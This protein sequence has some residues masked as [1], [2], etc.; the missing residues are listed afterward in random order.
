MLE[1]IDMINSSEVDNNFIGDFINCLFR[2]NDEIQGVVDKLYSLNP[3]E[4][5]FD[6]DINMISLILCES[7]NYKYSEI[8]EKSSS[9]KEELH[10]ASATAQKFG[11]NGLYKF[12]EK[13][14][15]AMVVKKV[16]LLLENE[17]PNV[18]RS[19]LIYRMH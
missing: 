9:I 4:D 14:I 6:I 13:T 3:S 19:E 7:L 2:D 16:I 12:L 17:K 1:V 10:I 5:P 18:N 8:Y 11:C 15:I